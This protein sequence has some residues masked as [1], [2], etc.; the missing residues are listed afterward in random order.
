MSE[1]N[2][3]GI[4]SNMQA[5]LNALREPQPAGDLVQRIAAVEEAA[6]TA[7]Q[8]SASAGSSGDAKLLAALLQQ[9]DYALHALFMKTF[10]KYTFRE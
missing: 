8:I 6:S 9:V 3:S 7:R 1:I 5:A 10:R 2:L 4:I